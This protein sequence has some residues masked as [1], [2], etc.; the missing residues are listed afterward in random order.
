MQGGLENDGE[1][2]AGGGRAGKGVRECG[3][4][5]KGRKEVGRE[6]GRKGGWR[7]EFMFLMQ[8]GHFGGGIMG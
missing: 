6:E 3:M 8:K 4:P 7:M 5:E 1:L 2:E